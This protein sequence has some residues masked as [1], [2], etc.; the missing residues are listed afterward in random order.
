MQ[1]VSFWSIAWL[2]I[3]KAIASRVTFVP[4]RFS[5]HQTEL[6]RA[7]MCTQRRDFLFAFTSPT[8]LIPAATGIWGGYVGHDCYGRLGDNTAAHRHAYSLFRGSCEKLL[9]C[10]TCD[11]PSCV[12]PSHLFLGTHQHNSDDK[13]LKGREARGE[14][15]ATHKL[16]ADDVRAIRL[17]QSTCV[18]P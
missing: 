1:H 6:S 7:F 2:S 15:V 12:R 10:H 9:V 13:L 11:T 16:T 4:T 3:M 17:S 18:D 14:K 8:T 5:D